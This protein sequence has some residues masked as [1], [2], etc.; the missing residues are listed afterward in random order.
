MEGGGGLTLGEDRGGEAAPSVSP[1]GHPRACQRATCHQ[2]GHAHAHSPLATGVQLGNTT[3][4]A[5]QRGPAW[6]R[7]GPRI[8]D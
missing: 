1:G 8:K 3:S 5:G 4:T 7:T 6:V 2:K